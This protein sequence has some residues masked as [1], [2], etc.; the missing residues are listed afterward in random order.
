M[1][2]QRVI[3]ALVF[4]I[5]VVMSILY[6]PLFAFRILAEL[7]VALAA[8]E[9]AEFFWQKEPKKK[10]GFLIAFLLVSIFVQF[11]SA[12]PVL[13]VAALW[14][15]GATYFL[16]RY[17]LEEKNFFT[18]TAS[19]YFVGI[20]IFVPCVLG[21]VE[22]QDKLG[23]GFLLYILTIICAVDI[24]AY[25]TGKTLG[26]HLLAPKISPK[27][28]VEGVIG[29]VVLALIVT[30][31]GAFLL[32]F[33]FDDGGKHSISFLI[34]VIVMCLWSVIGD[35]FESML[36]RQVGVKDSGQLLPGHGGMYDRIDSL[37]AAIPIF[38]LGLWII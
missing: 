25:F 13:I 22:I 19:Q 37:T 28:T 33:S 11:F 29:G 34:L 17:T 32:G 1:L 5:M 18:N 36:K 23:A 31:I 8:W 12:L 24:G 35:L 9:F 3:T 20:L 4:G 27:K 16:W 2:I 6:L 26:R 21:L 7:I 15:L 30:V 14:W 38:V 10:I